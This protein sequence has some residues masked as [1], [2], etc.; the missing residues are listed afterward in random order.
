MYIGLVVC[1]RLDVQSYT[2]KVAAHM[3]A[4]R[5]RTH[6]TA[7]ADWWR[8]GDGHAPFI[9]RSA[10]SVRAKRISICM[11]TC[12][13]QLLRSFLLYFVILFLL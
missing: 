2:A 13:E 11:Y 12:V 3:K 6:A 9:E 5:A 8:G 4:A 7:A 10:G 1:G